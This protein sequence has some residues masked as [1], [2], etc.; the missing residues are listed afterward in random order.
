MSNPD[1][2]LDAM[3]EQWRSVPPP[4]P[5][6]VR[7]E[8]WRRIAATE[9]EGRTR[10]G[11]IARITA[12]LARPAVAIAFGAACVML[13]V[14]LA[15]LRSSRLEHERSA[16]L[17]RSYLR[18][19]DP[20][21]ATEVARAGPTGGENLDAE[22]AWM[23]ASLQ[24][25]PE[26]LARIRDLH[27]Q[28]SPQ[29]QRLAAQVGRMRQEFAVFEHERTTAG[30]IDFLEFARFV[31]QRRAVDRE[32]S[33]STRKLIQAAGEVMTASQRERY[34][35]LVSPATDGATKGALN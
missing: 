5:E 8:V 27:T 30:Q 3:L 26:Q 33:E 32:C 15:E 35:T 10:R 7:T 16:R 11:W 14:L 19:I 34:L 13:G 23:Q 6:P 1:D 20:Q 25:T 4:L 22:L 31:E 29:L 18:L 28:S 24:L 17:A 9:A 12:A 21:L 2:P